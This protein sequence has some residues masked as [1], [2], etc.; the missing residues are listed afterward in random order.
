MIQENGKL[1]LPGTEP[2][3]VNEAFAL[4]ED[5]LPQMVPYCQR[6]LAAHAGDQAASLKAA[7]G[8]LLSANWCIPKHSH[9]IVT[10]AAK[11]LDWPSP[12]GLAPGPAPDHP[13]AWLLPGAPIHAAR[14]RSARRSPAL[15]P[16]DYC[17]DIQ[18]FGMYDFRTK[19]SE[20]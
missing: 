12:V 3:Q 16:A 8:G 5:L 15:I 11:R 13:A 6:N 10:R 7:F 18:W 20:S 14:S 9:W 19:S 2:S 1:F 17:I 4:C